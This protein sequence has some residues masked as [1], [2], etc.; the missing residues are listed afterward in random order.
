MHRGLLDDDVCMG[1]V[2]TVLIE[3]FY[4]EFARSLDYLDLFKRFKEPEIER[5][6]KA[7]N[8]KNT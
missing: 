4:C 6:E 1:F 7:T 5:R 3:R 8:K 2:M